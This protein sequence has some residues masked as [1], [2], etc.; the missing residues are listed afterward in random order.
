M[1]IDSLPD[2]RCSA[3]VISIGGKE[4]DTFKNLIAVRENSFLIVSPVAAA[5]RMCNTH[6][7]GRAAV[8]SRLSR[9]SVRF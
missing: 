9:L 8:P 1:W 5:K 7:A 3:P 6:L 4:L 2:S